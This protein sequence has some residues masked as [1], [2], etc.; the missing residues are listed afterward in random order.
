[1]NLFSYQVIT[2]FHFIQMQSIKGLTVRK[3]DFPSGKRPHFRQI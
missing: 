1:M 3:D 2:C